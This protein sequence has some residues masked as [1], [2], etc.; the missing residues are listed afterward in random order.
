MLLKSCGEWGSGPEQTP[1][2]TPKYRGMSTENPKVQL[3]D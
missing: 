2:K 3:E 1:L